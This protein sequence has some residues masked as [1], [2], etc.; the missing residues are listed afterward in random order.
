MVVFLDGLLSVSEVVARAGEF[1]SLHHHMPTMKDEDE[2]ANAGSS[3][4]CRVF[5]MGLGGLKSLLNI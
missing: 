1:Q 2:E 4:F 5:G 3:V